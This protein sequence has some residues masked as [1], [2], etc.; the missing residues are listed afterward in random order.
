VVPSAD[1][2][3][4]AQTQAD[5][6]RVPTVA[7]RTLAALGLE[8]RTADQFL[9]RSSVSAS[10]TADLLTF[11]VTDPDRQLASR[12]ATTYA[13][14]YTSYRRQLDTASLTRARRQLA[15]QLTSL[16][17]QGRRGSALYD[18]LLEKD[19]QLATMQA[20]QTSNAAVVRNA[21][22]AS[23]VQ[24]KTLR[25]ALL[26]FVLGSLLGVGLAFLR[27]ALDTRVRSAEELQERLGLPLLARLPEPPRRLRKEDRL[28]MLEGPHAR[29]A[30]PFRIL[31]VNLEFANIE[32][33][34]R[35]I[36]VTSA[37]EGE[38]KSTTVANLAVA[39]ARNGRNVILADLDLRN[40]YLHRFFNLQGGPGIT[41][42]A[43]GTARLDEA[44]TRI[45][46]LDRASDEEPGSGGN[47][48]VGG[49]LEVLPSGSAPQSAGE[50]AHSRAL[51]GIMAQLVERADLVLVDAP[52]L[53][54]VG[55]AVA[56]S[57]QLD[58]MLVVSRLS[59]VRTPIVNELQRVLSSCPAPAI[60]LVATGAEL[61]QGYA[62]SGYAPRLSEA[63]TEP[64]RAP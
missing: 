55:D 35:S 5:L 31:A 7:R 15:N 51:A 8:D 39:L 19:Q 44:L 37:R 48:K 30:E 46:L 13:R 40:P 23:Q 50:F 34:A 6:A 12:L 53:L 16:E 43:L 24:P 52:P 3:R 10:S 22:N 9:G 60:G 17:N 49:F 64:E 59:L 38:G 20:L 2:A 32:R 21:D 45:P 28:V 14:Q 33:G 11:S 56:L 54:G 41:Q 63:A 36:M 58:V 26:G 25:N 47:G 18:S 4:V 57:G 42:V 61:S 1:P 27:E 62:Y 29:E